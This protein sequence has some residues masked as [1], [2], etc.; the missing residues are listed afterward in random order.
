VDVSYAI[1]KQIGFAE[2]GIKRLDRESVSELTPR[3][4][5]W[6]KRAR[7]EWVAPVKDRRF[8]AACCGELQ[9]GRLDEQCKGGKE[10]SDHGTGRQG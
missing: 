3:D 9:Y 4:L 5:S 7:K 1:A 2:K 10:E 8:S 6:G